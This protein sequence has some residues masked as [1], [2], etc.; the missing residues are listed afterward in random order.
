MVS[1]V[2]PPR[3]IWSPS[4]R[5]TGWLAGIGSSSALRNVP[6]VESRSTSAQLPFRLAHEDRVAM[7]DTR[8]LQRARQIDLGF[9]GPA[10]AR[11]GRS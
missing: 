6:F 11:D 5:A 4:D 7:R 1:V 2:Q 8:V 3:W 9:D 10:R